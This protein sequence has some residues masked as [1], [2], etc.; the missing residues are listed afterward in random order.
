MAAHALTGGVAGPSSRRWAAFGAV[1]GAIVVADQASKA[2]VTAAVPFGDVVP[3]AGDLLRIAP[4]PNSGAIFGLFRDQ[5]PLFAVL[6]LAVLAMIVVYHAR[7]ARN[8]LLT[9]ALGLLL[10][11]AV[12]NLIDRFRLGYV[13][14]FVDMGI[15]DLRWYTYNVADASITVSIALLLLLAL[16]GE[17]LPGARRA[18]Q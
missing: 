14:D 1:A 5:A 11:G 4:A 6:S 7:S 12:G 10:G 9:L 17:R 8:V 15:G 18:R 3:L 2:L 16:L 13:L